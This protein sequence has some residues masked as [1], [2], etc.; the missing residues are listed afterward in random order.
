MLESVLHSVFSD[1]KDSSL[2]WPGLIR[3]HVSACPDIIVPLLVHFGVPRVMEQKKA[4]DPNW[5][6]PYPEYPSYPFPP[7][8][9]KTVVTKCLVSDGS[10]SKVS[11]LPAIINQQSQP[12]MIPQTDEQFQQVIDYIASISQEAGFDP[13]FKIDGEEVLV[14]T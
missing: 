13:K 8:S 1:L 2:P 11:F 10:I 7:D 12:E 5:N 4:L 9:R 6:P 3:G 14:L